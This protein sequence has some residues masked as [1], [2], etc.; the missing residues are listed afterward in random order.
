MALLSFD[1]TCHRLSYRVIAGMVLQSAQTKII[2][3]IS[4][5]NDADNYMMIGVFFHY[6]LR[7]L[8]TFKSAYYFI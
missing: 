3:I 6:L 7:F 4:L 5:P 1:R 2:F 8:P